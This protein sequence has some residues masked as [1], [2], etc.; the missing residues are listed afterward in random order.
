MWKYIRRYLHFAVLAALF[1]VGEVMMDLIQPG[2]MSRIVD[3]GVLGTTTGGV[4][5]LRLIW[6]LGLQMMGLV[7]VGGLSG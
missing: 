6:Q 2:I 3:E 1:M 4:G 7:I 5:N